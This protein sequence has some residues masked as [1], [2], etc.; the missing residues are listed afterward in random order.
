MIEFMKKEKTTSFEHCERYL[1][2]M[3]I[4]TIVFTSILEQ[5]CIKHQIEVIA[6]NV[7]HEKMMIDEFMIMITKN[8]DVEKAIKWLP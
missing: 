8:K 3:E 5:Q 2:Q 6:I 7:D 4:Y 1:Q